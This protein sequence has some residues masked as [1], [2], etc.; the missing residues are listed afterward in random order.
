MS[1]IPLYRAAEQLG[2]SPSYLKA[3]C[4]RLGIA[5]WPRAGRSLGGAENSS[6]RAAVN[7]EYSRRLLRKYA[8]DPIR[9]GLCTYTN[10]TA[11]A[12]ECPIPPVSLAPADPSCGAFSTQVRFASAAK[13]A[14]F[15]AAPLQPW[16]SEPLWDSPAPQPEPDDSALCPSGLWAGPAD[17]PDS[18]YLLCTLAGGFESAADIGD[19]VDVGLWEAPSHSE[20]LGAAGAGPCD[21]WASGWAGW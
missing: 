13:A 18:D 11:T 14:R 7:I 17:G 6:G 10:A 16:D 21:A 1:D 9:A 8:P 12:A 20:G 4:R 5:R 3:T 19:G 15:E 2:M